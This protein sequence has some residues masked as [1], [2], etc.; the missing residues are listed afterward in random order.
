MVTTISLHDRVE[1]KTLLGYC[2]QHK[3]I[4][5]TNT[6]S[7][8]PIEI[9][10]SGLR[11]R[12]DGSDFFN[13]KVRI[14]RDLWVG[15]VT[16][17]GKSSEWN[18]SNYDTDRNYNN[19]ILVVCGEFDS[20][21]QNAEG[22]TI[23]VVCQEVP[24]NIRKNYQDL[25]SN[26]A[27]DNPACYKVI[28]ELSKLMIHA[29]LAALQTER[30]EIK[31]EKI[32]SRATLTKSWEKAYLM[33]MAHSFGFGYN[34]DVF[35]KWAESL[36][37][38]AINKH[39]NDLFQIEAVFL[40]QAGLLELSTIPTKFQENALNE[41][42]FGKLRNE[43]LYLQRKYSLKPINGNEWNMKGITPQNYPHIRLSQMANLYYMQRAGMINII[44]C[45]TFQDVT[46]LLHTHA[47]PY[48]KLHYTFGAIEK[49]KK[50]KNL[51][52]ASVN[53]LMINA[54]VPFLF[55]YGRFVDKED[56]CD[57]AFYYIEMIKAEKN[58][59]T[60]QWERVGIKV[61]TASDSQALIQLKH[62]YCN[63][64]NCLCCRFGHKYL[65]K[66]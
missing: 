10:D 3:V 11:N 61:Q 27:N 18:L 37:M 6:I 14:D 59:L 23:D 63:N 13:A 9:I 1:T 26:A 46:D 49:N 50:E 4:T 21:I 16:I 7:G 57:K 55:A 58:V 25:L 60:K 62:H 12:Q 29:W 64:R 17:L 36:P 53:S 52:P 35:E 30:L 32:R 34:N 24:E 43:Y 22:Q 19:T 48:W 42:Y 56:L 47:T 45:K 41:G 31:T 2:F 5:A 28:P 15:N 54:I 65:A 39:R 8:K 66:N 44:N 51:S 40:G 38:D 20:F 33:T